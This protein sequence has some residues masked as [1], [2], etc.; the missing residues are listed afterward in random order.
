MRTSGPYYQLDDLPSDTDEAFQSTAAGPYPVEQGD[1]AKPT[2]FNSDRQTRT[3]FLRQSARW[4]VTV[5]FVSFVA[6]TFKIYEK[7]GNVPPTQKSTFNAIITA[8]ILGLGL[9]FFVSH[10]VLAS[11]MQVKSNCYSK[12]QEAF[13]SAAKLLRWRILA[14]KGH[15]IR[16]VDLI[17]GVENL[18]NVVVLGL[19]SLMK[20]ATLLLCISWVSRCC[21]LK[22]HP[23][24]SSV[25]PKVSKLASA[26]VLD[27]QTFPFSK[28]YLY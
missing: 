3:L 10:N 19:E 11:M 21:A 5:I 6:I 20:P 7:K 28:Y 18:T 25:P 26:L 23:N 16:E 12:F 24:K 8:L 9:N 22:G 17:V 2:V 4:L 15:S 13:K 27:F 1:Y 14:R